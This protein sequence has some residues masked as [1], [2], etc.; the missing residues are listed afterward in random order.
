MPAGVAAQAAVGQPL[1]ELRRRRRRCGARG[2][3][4][5]GRRRLRASS[6]QDNTDSPRGKCPPRSVRYH[7]PMSIRAAILA[8]LAPRCAPRPRAALGPD[9]D[10]RRPRRPR[11][12]P[13]VTTLHD[14]ERPR[15][16]RRAGSRPS[17]TARVWFLIPSNDRIVQLQP[18]GV[19]IKQWQIRDDKN[20]GANPVD[21][22]IDGNYRL[23][24][25]ERREPDRRRAARPSAASTRPPARC[26]SGSSRAR[27][28][29]GFYRA[30]DGKFWLPQTNG[31]LAVARPEHARGRGL[32]LEPRPSPT[33]TS[34]VGPDGALWLIDFGNN[35]IVRYVPGAPTE[36]SW[37]LLR[38]DRRPAEPVADRASTTPGNLW[39]SRALGEPAWTA[40]TRRPNADPSY[41]GFAD[42]DP[43]RPL[44]GTRSTSPRRPAATAAIVVLDPAAR[45]RRCGTL[46]PETL[47][48][49]G[50]RRT[51]CRPVDPRLDGDHPDD[52]HE[53]AGD[54]RADRPDV[55]VDRRP[56][57]SCARSSRRRTP[58][59]SRSTAAASGSA[60]TEALAASRPPDDRHR[61]RPRRSRRR[62]SSACRR[63]DRIAIDVDPLQ[64]G[65]RADLRRRPLP[66]LPRRLR[67]AHARSRSRPG[68]TRRSLRHVLGRRQHAT[69]R[70]SSAPCGSGSPSGNAGDLVASVRTAR[71]RDRRLVLRL[72][73]A[74]ARR[75]RT[76]SGAGS[77]RTL[78]TG[79]ARR[80]E[81]PS[82]AF[83]T[84]DGAGRDRDARRAGRHGPRHAPLR[85]S[86]RTSRRSSTPPPRPSASP[87]EPGDVDPRHRRLRVAPALRQHPRHR[88]PAT[89]RPRCPA[90]P[91]TRR[92]FP[93][94]RNAR[95]APGDTSFVSDLFL[96]N[97]RSPRTR[98]TSRSR[99]SR[100]A[101]DGAAADSR[102]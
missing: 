90:A 20:L 101:V 80:R 98:P 76:R 66:L 99:S 39:I 1:D 35:R 47:R 44:R 55:V 79:S 88:E 22:E 40:S 29:A 65:H 30:P 52:L 53:H 86:R 77:T 96:S 16:H 97:P 85:R 26:G 46:T 95:S 72:L 21:F 82:S 70:R 14:G 36:T 8:C 54:R 93:T 6:L 13:P 78:F 5:R 100:R 27:R 45:L 74:G 11:R 56:A 89:S 51:S 50:R 28:P 84:P 41:G 18:D 49:R 42:P 37:T 57:A 62:R 4:R 73:D 58:T 31:R 63:G 60:R 7:P 102:P 9:A 17:P 92:V 94:C 91:T 61:D 15:R 38:P 59:A 64:P 32:P 71:V 67:G 87:P 25:R 10:R 34:V 75:R 24:H 23:V 48:R 81:S 12:S 69:R 43:L 83:Y 68:E 2:S 19:T 33:P 3:G